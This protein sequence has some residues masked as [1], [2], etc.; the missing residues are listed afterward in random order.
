MHENLGFIP[1]PL[2]N[3]V[4]V[5]LSRPESIT[6]EAFSSEV[7][8]RRPVAMVV[9]PQESEDSARRKKEAFINLAQ[10]MDRLAEAQEQEQRRGGTT[11]AHDTVS[12]DVVLID[13]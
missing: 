13:G 1:P 9:T 7:D 12:I 6:E 10:E 3:T 4:P 5:S 11:W 8:R 2:S